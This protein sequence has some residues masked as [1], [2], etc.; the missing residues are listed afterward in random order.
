MIGAE[1]QIAGEGTGSTNHML[2]SIDHF[3]AYSLLHCLIIG[4][5]VAVA[6]SLGVYRRQLR[7]IDAPHARLLDLQVSWVLLVVWIIEQSFE[8]LPTRFSMA[9]SLPLHFCDI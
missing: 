5:I 6:V 1:Q 9:E 4:V 2:A 8:F 7:R 3:E